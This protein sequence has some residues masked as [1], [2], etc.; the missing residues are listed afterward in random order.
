MNPTVGRRF[1]EVI[2]SRAG[3]KPAA[4]MVREILGHDPSPEA[5]FEEI[6]GQRGN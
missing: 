1:R 4:Q 3:E 6:T 5:L 2:L